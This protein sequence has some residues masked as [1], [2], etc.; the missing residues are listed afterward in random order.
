M[1]GGH[2]FLV[3]FGIK[4]DP[5]RQTVQGLMVLPQFVDLG[6]SKGFIL[7][8]LPQTDRCPGVDRGEGPHN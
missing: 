1:L 3:F 8:Q 7:E 2:L 6:G 5:L 4:W